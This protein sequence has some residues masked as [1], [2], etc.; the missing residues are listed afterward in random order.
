MSLLHDEEPTGR[1]ARAPRGERRS[2]PLQRRTT[3]AK[4][5]WLVGR[6]LVAAGIVV[7]A[8]GAAAYFTWKLQQQQMI[9]D[10]AV[11]ARNAAVQYAHTLTEIDP[12]TF[13]RNLS[14]AL[15]GATGHFKD[16]YTRASVQI[17]QLVIANNQVAHGAIVGSAIESKSAATVVILIMVNQTV[18]QT[19]P[20]DPRINRSRMKITMEKVDGSWRAGNVELR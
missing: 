4:L 9:D 3:K 16:E 10:A 20:P 2:R 14:E 17:R 11:D 7:A 12:K 5:I 6:R 18:T 13:D 19:T 15:N 8:L 1:S